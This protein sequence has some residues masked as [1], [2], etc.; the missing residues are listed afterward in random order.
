MKPWSSLSRFLSVLLLGLLLLCFSTLPSFSQDSTAQPSSSNQILPSQPSSSA[1][2][3]EP[4]PQAQQQPLQLPQTQLVPNSKPWPPLPAQLPPSMTPEQAEQLLILFWPIIV[5]FSNNSD[6][7]VILVPQLQALLLSSAA[8][9][10]GQSSSINSGQQASSSAEQNATAA[11]QS[12]QQAAASAASSQTNSQAAAS[13][14]QASAS[15]SAAAMAPLGDAEK[16]A[17]R[18]SLEITVLKVGIVTVSVVAAGEGVY[19]LGHALK[20]W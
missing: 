20:A 17:D 15:A 5:D 12:A 18:M 14:A 9:V 7:L 6:K 16:Q 3:T 19:I 8:I 4:Q 13:Q 1:S 10:T 11:G 2:P